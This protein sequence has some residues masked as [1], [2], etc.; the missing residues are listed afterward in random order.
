MTY[1]W[2]LTE[3]KLV[4]NG[5][6]LDLYEF[7]NRHHDCTYDSF[8]RWL[9]LLMGYNWPVKNF[10]TSKALRQSVIRLFSRLT[11]LKKEHNSQVK[12][13]L[14]RGFLCESYCLPKFMVHGKLHTSSSSNSSSSCHELE[15]ENKIL[16]SQNA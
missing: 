11:K 6:V 12:D 2:F 14:I 7:M 8:R 4:S 13:A 5:L 15:S 10:P 3:D 16:K 9:A 1:Q